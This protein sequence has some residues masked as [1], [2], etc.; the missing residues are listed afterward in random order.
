MVPFKRGALS[1]RFLPAT[2]TTASSSAV[3]LP[4]DSECS[5]QIIGS[6]GCLPYFLRNIVSAGLLLA[7]AVAVVLIIISGIKLVLSGGD[8]E[9][10]ASAKKSLTFTI[11]GLLIVL[12]AFVI[13]NL[14]ARVTGANI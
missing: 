4:T 10:V 12:F 1:T 14:I 3:S 6:I 9:K 8:P 11:I 5:T 13:I 7:A 2:I